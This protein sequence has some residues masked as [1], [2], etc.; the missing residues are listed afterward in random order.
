M[1]KKT[2]LFSIVGVLTLALAASLWAQETKNTTTESGI[3][4]WQHLAFEQAGNIITGD[5][6][7]AKKINQ[8]GNEGWELVNVETMVRNGSTYKSIFFFKRPN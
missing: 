6:K 5:P 8:L 1:M 2:T 3:K 4:K 7:L